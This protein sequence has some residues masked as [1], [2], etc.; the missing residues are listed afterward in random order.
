METIY[1]KEF[2]E[3]KNLLQEVNDFM[4]ENKINESRY[5]ALLTED[6]GKVLW[7]RRE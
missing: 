3:S 4:V 7:Y 5:I 1:C 2:K 6:D